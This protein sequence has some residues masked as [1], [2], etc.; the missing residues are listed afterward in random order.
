MDHKEALRIMKAFFGDAH[1]EVGSTL[2]RVAVVLNAQ[3]K[4]EDAAS[5]FEES[6]RTFLIVYGADGSKTKEASKMAEEARAKC[7]K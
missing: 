1:A 2:H 3:G 6:A 7:V 4:L 5:T